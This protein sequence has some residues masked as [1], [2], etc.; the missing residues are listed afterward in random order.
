MKE[1]EM[2]NLE[3]KDLD[4]S[5]LEIRKGDASDL[6]AIE[7]LASELTAK[8]PSILDLENTVTIDGIDIEIKPTKLKYA[9]NMFTA[10]F[11][12][13]KKI[14]ISDFV[15]IPEGTLDKKRSGDQILFDFIVAVLDDPSFVQDH[16]DNIDLDTIDR[17]MKIYERVNHI[18][19]RE[20]AARKNP[21][22]QTTA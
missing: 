2:S 18:K 8:A 15:I 11:N 6:E 21:E 20:E 13:L 9:R 12:Y 7:L 22:A 17:I 14:P 1:I 10:Y 3:S 5:K 19:E 16:Y 4:S